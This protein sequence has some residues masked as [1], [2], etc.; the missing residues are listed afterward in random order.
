[1]VEK[2]CSKIIKSKKKYFTKIR[3][4]KKISALNITIKK[5]SSKK[6]IIQE[7][8]TMLMCTHCGGK[9]LKPI[10]PVNYII[11]CLECFRPLDLPSTYYI[12]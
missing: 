6:I 3:P 12:F 11:H 7:N 4:N 10:L 2:C 1:M 8:T 5:V 9:V